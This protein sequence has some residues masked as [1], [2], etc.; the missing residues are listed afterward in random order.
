VSD[1]GHGIKP[2]DADRIFQPF[3]R[4]EHDK[5]AGSGAGLGLAIAQRIAV[6]QGGRVRYDARQGGGSVFTLDLPV[7]SLP[8]NEPVKV[9]TSP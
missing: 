7:A 1:R 2:A 4:G 9:L 8:E 6:A 3:V 5:S